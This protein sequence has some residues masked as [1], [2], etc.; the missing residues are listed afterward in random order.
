MNGAP[1]PAEAPW[2]REC[3]GGV[4]P[5]REE[6]DQSTGEGAAPGAPELGEPAP[7]APAVPDES[8][9]PDDA[10]EPLELSPP[11]EL[12]DAFCVYQAGGA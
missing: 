4:S 3:A 12:C 7:A 10:A 9:P 1:G 8:T 5:G 2:G 11:P 6:A